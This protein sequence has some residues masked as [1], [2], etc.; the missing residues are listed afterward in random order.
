MSGEYTNSKG[1]TYFLH[2]RVTTLKNGQKQT[3]YFFAKERK[4]GALDDVPAG[5]E[6]SESRN[7]LPVLKKKPVE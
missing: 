6:P 7:G 2:S 3:I 1:K 4:E 5:Y